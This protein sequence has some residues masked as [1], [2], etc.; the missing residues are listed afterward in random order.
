M[1]NNTASPCS[2]MQKPRLPRSLSV[3][4]L[5][6]QPPTC[7]QNIALKKKVTHNLS[8]QRD[9]LGNVIY[10]K[11]KSSF[12]G[13][14]IFSKVIFHIYAFKLYSI[15]YKNY[16]N[17]PSPNMNV[18]IIVSAL[19][20]FNTQPEIKYGTFTTNEE[21]T[22]RSA[23]FDMTPYIQGSKTSIVHRMH[24][25]RHM[26]TPTPFSIQYIWKCNLLYV[27]W[28]MQFSKALT[29]GAS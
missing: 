26:Y 4:Q 17:C 16:S 22:N 12:L 23:G 14:A 3:V 15:L 13:E 7:K 11:K 10:K 25:G 2:L 24:K 6:Q 9:W 18:I 5:V 8:R 27:K 19:A 21:G 20:H 29:T 28:K 1:S